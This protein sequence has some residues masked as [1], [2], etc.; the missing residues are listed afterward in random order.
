MKHYKVVILGCGASGAMCA[1][2]A[3]CDNLAVIDANVS[4]AKKILVTGNGRCNL[5]NINP[6]HEAYNQNIDK[7][8][9]KFGIE[10]TLAFFQSIGLEYCHDEEGRVYPL[11][12]TAKSVQDV[13]NNALQNKVDFYLGQYVTE[14]SKVSKGFIVVTDKEK[15][16]C[17]KLVIATGG[18]SIVNSL[19]NLGVN[20]KPFTPS[21]VA[22]KCDNIDGLNGVR[23]PY[24]KVTA[25]DL[26]GNSV[27]KYGEVLFRDNGLSGIVIFNTS[28]L[29]ARKGI[30]SGNVSIDLLPNLSTNELL[31][32]I[33]NRKNINKDINKLFVGMFHN[34]V[35][36]EIFKQAKIN[37]NCNV[38]SEDDVNKLAFV[39]KNLSY[40]VTGH[41]DNNQ[42]FSGGVCLDA[43][44]DNLMSK[45]MPNLYFTGEVCDVDGVCGGYNLQWAW[46]SGHIV[47]EA[48]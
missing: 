44:T 7:Y 13:I 23:V 12:N 11:S 9:N 39:I 48:L 20:F 31:K 36:N 32:K 26:D 1:L 15:F 2:S 42:V 27:S 19:V 33:Q 38:L 21:L 46:T 35:A 8:L 25:N 10:D 18:N 30:F 24:V 43:L 6:S 47:G 45:S 16:E 4:P 28:T 3:K 29:F 14:I 22:L 37:T 34:A 17:N 40:T 41:L 5:T